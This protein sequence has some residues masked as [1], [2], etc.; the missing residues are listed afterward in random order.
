MAASPNHGPRCGGPLSP[1]PSDV[2]RESGPSRPTVTVWRALAAEGGESSVAGSEVP[3][4]LGSARAAVDHRGGH[5]QIIASV[6]DGKTEVVAQRAAA[7]GAEGVAPSAIVAFTFTKRAAVE[8]KER[9]R[10][11]VEAASGDAAV[12]L[13]GQMFVGTIH[14]YCF[15]LLQAYVPRYE[16]YDPLDENQ[17][18]AFLQRET[19]RLGLPELV[20]AGQFAS[21]EAFARSVDVIEN[22]MLEIE[23][24]DDPLRSVV[25]AYYA[26]LERYKLLSYGLQIVRAVEALEDAEVHSRVT[27][28][29]QHLVVDEYQDVNP[30]QERLIQLLAKPIGQADLAVVGDDDQAI[31]QW[32]GSDVT[33]IVGFADRYPDVTSFDLM[34]NRRSRPA[35]VALADA[36]AQTIPGRLKKEMTPVRKPAGP[37]VHVVVH[38]TELEEAED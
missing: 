2:D 16:S 31:Y 15:R 1:W 10:A 29:V 18:A 3:V 37:A 32:R 26:T 27:A 35:I 17:L 22:E 8:L 9:I 28:D 12:D 21:I 34:S 19:Y 14:A 24:L 5:V 30:A 6:V 23:A 38:D 4:L 36:F 20:G 13:L 7:L 25:T 11:R 33:N